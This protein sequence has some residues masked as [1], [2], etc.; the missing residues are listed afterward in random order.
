MTASPLSLAST[1]NSYDILAYQAPKNSTTGLIALNARLG[2]SAG[3]GEDG[4]DGQVQPLAVEIEF[5]A[6]PLA[7]FDGPRK[8]LVLLLRAPQLCRL[9]PNEIRRGPPDNAR[10]DLVGDEHPTA[11]QAKP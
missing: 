10:E 5:D 2:E 4:V 11:R 6:F 8:W 1:A 3:L 9:E 7:A